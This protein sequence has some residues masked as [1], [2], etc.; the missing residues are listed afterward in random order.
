MNA[1]L[2]MKLIDL[3]IAVATGVPAAIEAAAKVKAMAAEGRDPTEA[4]WAALTAV[5]DSLHGQIQGT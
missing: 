3:G 5:T 1:L 4:E 2:A